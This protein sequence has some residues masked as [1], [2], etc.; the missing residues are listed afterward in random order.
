MS[1]TQKLT[2]IK[3]GSFLLIL[4][5]VGGRNL[6]PSPR[7]SKL[8]SDWLKFTC[9]LLKTLRRSLFLHIHYGVGGN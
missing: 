9:V 6:T 4:A 2:W 5:T 7:R 3:T 1:G 8:V